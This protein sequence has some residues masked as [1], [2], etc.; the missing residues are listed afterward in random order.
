MRTYATWQEMTIIS[1]LHMTA[2]S[3][4]KMPSSG[5][6]DF[7]FISRGYMYWK[8]VSGEKGAFSSHHCIIII[9]IRECASTL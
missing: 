6:A 2:V 7:A 9:I 1:T 4:G 3:R 8:D 5:N